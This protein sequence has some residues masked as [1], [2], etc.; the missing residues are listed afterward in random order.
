MGKADVNGKW[1]LGG[2]PDEWVRWL[3]D[4]PTVEVEEFLSAEFRHIL[5]QSDALMRVRDERG[6]FLLLVELQLRYDENM[7]RRVEAYSALAEEKYRL[8]VYPIVFYLLPPPSGVRLLERY[9]QEL[10]GLVARRDF[11][12]VK[13]W[14]MDANE[15]VERGP[16]ALIPLTPLMRG[17]DEQT[18]REGV[19][20]LRERG[21]EEEMEVALALFASFMMDAD[22]IRRIVRWEMA[23]LRESPW[24]QQIISE[25]IQIG[26]K[27][28]WREGRLEGQREGR[29]E[30]WKEGLAEAVLQMLRV[31]FGVRGQ[32]YD[33]LSARI[34]RVKD[35]NVLRRLLVDALVAES[36]EAF[37]AA[38][39]APAS[40]GRGGQVSYS[41]P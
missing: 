36:L 35:P 24:Y 7:P 41:T 39:D 1:L 4:D 28:G 30:G 27:E 16:L 19:R 12:V 33:M 17:A 22:Q 37:L 38:L 15:V 14:E 18:V 9:Y 2:E 13:A 8:P 26:R 20:A 6:H 10:R 25:G 34:Q 5:R 3:L 11:R 31:K 21:G 23:T 32:E 29:K 40:P